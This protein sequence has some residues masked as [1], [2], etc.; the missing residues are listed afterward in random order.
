MTDPRLT[1]EAD[2]AV[3]S[4]RLLGAIVGAFHAELLAQQ[5]TPHTATYLSYWLM[6][7]YL[8]VRP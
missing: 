1:H 6:N 8:P 7:R 3:A 5:M 4:A 2:Q